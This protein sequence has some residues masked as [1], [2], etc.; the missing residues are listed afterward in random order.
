MRKILLS[1]AACAALLVPTLAA[2]PALA[3]N[4]VSYV[5]S[6]GN[7]ANDCATA[8]TACATFQGAY[9]KT[10]AGGGIAVVDSGSY[11]S[12][13]INKS[14]H[15]TND[16]AGEA[17]ILPLVSGIGIGIFGNAGD[18]VSL[19]GLVID[20]LDQAGL[21]VYI[22]SA[23]AVHIQNCVVR[24]LESGGFGIFFQ[25]SVAAQLFVSDTIVFNN[26]STAATGGIIVR[27]AGAPLRVALDRVHLE[28]N[29]RGLWVDGS[30]SSLGGARVVIRDSMVSGNAGDGILA[31]TTAGNAPA[32]IVVEHTTVMNGAATGIHADGPGATMLLND[33][34]VTGN[35]IGIG[36]VNGGQL[37]SYGNNKVNNNLGPDG[38]PTGSYSP[39]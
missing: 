29:V 8:A 5:S 13:N 12:L 33:D 10:S 38:A 9:S 22:G 1:A 23:S 28:N 24:N 35:A 34:T 27:A 11:G 4:A 7:N 30:Q 14:M 16:G 19:R 3:L 17:L 15:I 37:I 39:L 31:S 32:F 2:A 20:G 6:A 26:G 25:S 36:A 18:V 21:G